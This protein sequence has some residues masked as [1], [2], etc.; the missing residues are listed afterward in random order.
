MQGMK[1]VITKKNKKINI[2]SAT[3]VLFLILD[4]SK[5]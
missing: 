5:V 2:R 1:Y 3:V 4:T